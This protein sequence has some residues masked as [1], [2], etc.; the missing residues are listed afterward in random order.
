MANILIIGGGVSGLSAGIY[1]QMHGHHAIVCEQH[2]IPGGNLTGWDR[3]GYHIDNCIHWLTGTNPSSPL[4]PMWEDL[5]ALGTRRDKE[6]ARQKPSIFFISS[7][8]AVRDVRP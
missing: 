4:Y 2:F 3:G 8:T 6:K 1:A 7:R 5:G